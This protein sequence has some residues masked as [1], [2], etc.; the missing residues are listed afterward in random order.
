M[1]DRF[2]RFSVAISEIS[3]HWHKIASDEME[4]YGLKGPHATYLVAISRHKEGLTASQLC[5]LCG[6]DKSDV[7][8][9]MSIMEQK[10]LVRKEDLSQRRY[11]GRFS[12]TE[13]GTL[14]A[15]QVR[16]RVSLAVELA[17]KD[18][19]DEKRAVFY[20]ALSLIAGN[21]RK[22]SKEGLPV[23]DPAIS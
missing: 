11:R 8:R 15:E 9:M 22:I 16:R 19:T 21:L 6:K 10:G 17:G 14:A 1:I 3:R 13:E 4:A 12:L 2:E 18:L 5:D 7:S 20:E 23:P